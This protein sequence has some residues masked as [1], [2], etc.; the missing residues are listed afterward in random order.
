MSMRRKKWLWMIPIG[1]LTLFFAALGVQTSRLRL[2]ENEVVAAIPAHYISSSRHFKELK[3]HVRWNQ[4]KGGQS[5]P[6][7]MNQLRKRYPRVRFVDEIASSDATTR[8]FRFEKPVF[9]SRYFVTCRVQYSARISLGV[10]IV[11]MA[12]F[13]EQILLTRSP[14]S[15]DSSW[16]VQRVELESV[17]F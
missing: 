10:G 3:M 13:Q 12:T 1:V 17:Q 11:D 8:S 2:D 9:K 4:R 14:L 5:S 15:F 6:R 16:Q 7:L